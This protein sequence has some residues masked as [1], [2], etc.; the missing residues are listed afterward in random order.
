ME[1]WIKLPSLELKIEDGDICLSTKIIFQGWYSDSSGRTPAW[2]AWAPKFK[3]PSTAKISKWIII[4]NY[5]LSD[6]I[7]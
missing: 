3:L 1:I 2:Q 5:N 7:I 6:A 4:N